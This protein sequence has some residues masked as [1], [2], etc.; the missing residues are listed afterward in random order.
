MRLLKEEIRAREKGTVNKDKP[1][2]GSTPKSP[3]PK[4][5]DETPTKKPFVPFKK[6]VPRMKA[7]VAQVDGTMPEEE[8][9]EM[10]EEEFQ[11]ACM[12]W[13]A[14]QLM[15]GGLK[16]ELEGMKQQMIIMA[17][18]TNSVLQLPALFQ[19][20]QSQVQA[21]APIKSETQ[22]IQLAEPQAKRPQ[23]TEP[24][25]VK[26]IIDRTKLET[27]FFTHRSQGSKTHTVWTCAIQP[28]QKSEELAK[29]N[30]CRVCW[31]CG[32]TGTECTV[33]PNIQCDHCK[34]LGHW[35]PFCG[36]FISMKIA[37][38]KAQKTQ[39]ESQ[40]PQAAVAA[41][42]ESFENYLKRSEAQAAHSSRVVAAN[43]MTSTSYALKAGAP[44][45]AVGNVL[46]PKPE[47]T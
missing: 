32:H 38:M 30:R 4:S 28:L 36:A 23:I 19:A 5:S 13:Q 11:Q 44:L 18:A 12:N 22:Q 29:M 7:H 20:S 1:I 10:T 40:A 2:L 17:N 25:A 9:E 46:T 37:S 6:F 45:K 34:M 39:G 3:V 43:S 41:A 21:A 16:E 31:Q 26:V 42:I 15:A 14:E 24:E 47:A 35:Q 33:R 27:C 8:Q